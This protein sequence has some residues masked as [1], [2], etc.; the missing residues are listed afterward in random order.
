MLFLLIITVCWLIM[1]ASFGLD[2][3][4]EGVGFILFFSSDFF[5]SIKVIKFVEYQIITVIA[6][7]LGIIWILAVPALYVNQKQQKKRNI[8]KRSEYVA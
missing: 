3:L 7:H 2:E 6:F 4:G 1:A 5:A 8:E